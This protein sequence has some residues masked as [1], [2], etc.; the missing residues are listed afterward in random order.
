MLF[1]SLVERKMTIIYVQ[2]ISGLKKN[3][4]ENIGAFIEAHWTVL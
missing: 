2:S 3:F 1:R 4:G